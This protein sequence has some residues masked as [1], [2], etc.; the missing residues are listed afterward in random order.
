MTAIA[1]TAPAAPLVR[2][3]TGTRRKGWVRRGPLLPALVFTIIVTQLP[4][5][6]TLYYSLESWSLVRP[7][8]QHMEV[9]FERHRRPRDLRLTG[10]FPAFSSIPP[11]GAAAV[12]RGCGRFPRVFPLSMTACPEAAGRKPG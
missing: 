6:V 12:P 2:A 8:S 3:R 5:L 10:G 7:G 11:S 1:P 9:R 4:F